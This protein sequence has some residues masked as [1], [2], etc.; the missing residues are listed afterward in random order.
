MKAGSVIRKDLGQSLSGAC[1]GRMEEEKKRDV[2]RIRV[3][4]RVGP[5]R[6]L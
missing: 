6:D 5:E 2:G 1:L 4:V 3:S